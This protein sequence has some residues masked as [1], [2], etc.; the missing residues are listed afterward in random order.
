MEPANGD[1]GAIHG[2][3]RDDRM[4]A[5]TVGEPGIHG[6]LGSVDAESERGD[7][8]SH[9]GDDVVVVPERDLAPFHDAVPFDPHLIGTVHE[10]VCHLVVGH[11]RFQR[12]KT[13]DRV[14]SRID[15]RVPAKWGNLTGDVAPMSN[16]FFSLERDVRLDERRNDAIDVAH[17]RLHSRATARSHGS[18][19]DGGLRP[20]KRAST[21]LLLGMGRTT[22]SGFRPGENAHL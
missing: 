19:F 6:G 7:D 20:A 8:P 13:H 15:G 2:G 16:E 22:P 17:G 3:W 4:E 9:H 14:H 21:V 5:G 11:Q 18:R 12:P 10:N 1:H